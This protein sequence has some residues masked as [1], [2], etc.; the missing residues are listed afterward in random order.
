M[1][2][3]EAYYKRAIEADP[4]DADN[5]GSYA[6][7]LENRR[8]DMEDAEA[9]YKRAIEADP[10]DADSLGSYAVFLEN[11][12]GDMDGAEAY[13]K[14][15]IE[16]DPK[17]ADNLSHYADFLE[18]RR[19]DMVAAEGIYRR[20]IETNPKHTG[21]LGNYGQ[22]LAGLGRLL[23]GERMLLSAFE[24]LD[25][26]ESADTAEVCFSLWLV[27]R[28]QDHDAELWERCFKFLIQQGFK[29][30]PWSFDHMLEQAKK[31]FAAEEFEYANA[32]ALAFLDESKVP[33]LE[34]YERWRKLE[35]LDP[36]GQKQLASS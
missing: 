31:K 12:R 23:D 35:P 25:A 5:L 2:G 13:Y 19:R 36:K 1:E 4:K 11:R 3:A 26:V 18:K 30:Y 14:R 20:A 22:Y 15:A 6:D 24:H 33:E 7:F 29:R 9:Y 16:A 21:A 10:K 32:L 17:E 8:G 27:L 34:R 28:M